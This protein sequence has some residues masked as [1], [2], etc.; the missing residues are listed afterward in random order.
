MSPEFPVAFFP[1]E[2][3]ADFQ[4]RTQ[5]PTES[6]NPAF[7]AVPGLRKQSLKFMASKPPGRQGNILGEKKTT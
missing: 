2:P 3:L 6:S 5:G 4:Y 7:A 1:F